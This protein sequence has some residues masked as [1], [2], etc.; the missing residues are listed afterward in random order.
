MMTA[1]LAEGGT[2]VAITGSYSSTNGTV[3]YSKAIGNG[4]QVWVIAPLART[5]GSNAWYSSERFWTNI[6]VGSLPASRLLMINAIGDSLILAWGIL[7]ILLIMEGVR[8]VWVHINRNRS[9]RIL[10]SKGHERHKCPS[11]GYSASSAISHRRQDERIPRFA[12]RHAIGIGT[13]LGVTILFFIPMVKSIFDGRI[14]PYHEGFLDVSDTAYVARFIS[15][16]HTYP[17]FYQ[18]RAYG[19]RMDATAYL[20][21]PLSIVPVILCLLGMDAVT[22]EILGEMIYVLIGVLALYWCA[23]RVTDS[24]SASLTSSVLYMS[25]SFLVSEVIS[26]GTARFACIFAAAPLLL[27]SLALLWSGKHR[28]L[29]LVFFS[30]VFAWFLGVDAVIAAATAIAA[31]S[32]L[33]LFE[34]QRIRFILL[35]G[36]IMVVGAYI[37]YSYVESFAS[38]FP[39]TSFGL[40]NGYLFY[41]TPS[42]LQVLGLFPSMLNGLPLFAQSPGLSIPA[43]VL[44]LLPLCLALVSLTVYRKGILLLIVAVGLLLLSAGTNGPFAFLFSSWSLPL[45]SPARAF[46]PAAAPLLA[47]LAAIAVARIQERSFTQQERKQ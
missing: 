44:G 2:I 22:S 1:Y 34:K 33:P 21:T 28:I 39:S 29:S 20:T 37:Y 31:Y 25:S 24:V 6:I 35:P 19:G 43:T 18:A 16:Y 11:A 32:A 38:L 13:L 4:V 45:R 23:Y 41:Q 3:L 10:Y 14:P 42:L 9:W 7:S 26:G 8:Y 12:Y 5:Y 30:L 46:I 15:S 47:L 17:L 36:V 27:L 40:N